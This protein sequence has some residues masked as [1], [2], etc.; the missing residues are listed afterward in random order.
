MRQLPHEILFLSPLNFEMPYLAIADNP[1]NPGW[2]A[3]CVS[4]IV[5]IKLIRDLL[6]H[7]D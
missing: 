3:R 4:I 1:R 7:T 2:K 6:R 5:S